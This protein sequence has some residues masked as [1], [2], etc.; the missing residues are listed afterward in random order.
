V[1]V[2]THAVDD[3]RQASIVAGRVE[4]RPGRSGSAVGS[5]RP[6]GVDELIAA[7]LAQPTAME[8]GGTSKN[9]YVTVR[10]VSLAAA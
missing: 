6:S 8:L 4:S 9:N 3:Q 1:E 10:D 2:R 7:R 5:S